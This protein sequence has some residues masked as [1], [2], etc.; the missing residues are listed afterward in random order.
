MRSYS[1]SQ[2]PVL[3]NTPEGEPLTHR[4]GE[5][6]LDLSSIL[7]AATSNRPGHG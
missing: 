7:I 4:P 5:A 1:C 6:I 2:V 3:Q